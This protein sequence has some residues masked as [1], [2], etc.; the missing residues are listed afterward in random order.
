MWVPCVRRGGEESEETLVR[1]ASV[2]VSWL[3][4]ISKSTYEVE[5][6]GYPVGLMAPTCSMKRQPNQSDAGEPA[7][8]SHTY[9][10]FRRRG[11]GLVQ[12]GRAERMAYS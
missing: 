9:P 5:P 4:F 3:L 2:S 6:Q 7:A 12:W 10:A 1:H 8:K 11:E